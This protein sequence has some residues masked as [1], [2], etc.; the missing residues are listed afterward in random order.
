MCQAHQGAFACG[1]P[2]QIEPDASFEGA[3]SYPATVAEC[4]DPM[5][6]DPAK[7][8][9]IK[10]NTQ[11]VIDNKDATTGHPWN[12]FIRFD[13]DDALAGHTVTHVA[14]RVTATDDSLAPSPDSGTP[15]SVAAFT[16]QSLTGTLPAKVGGPLVASKGP[17]TQLEAIDFELPPAIAAASSPVYIGLFPTNNDGVNYWNRDG[18]TPP[19]LLVDIE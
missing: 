17:V 6:P 11:L 1:L 5:Q 7:C 10:G 8:R 19:V 13:L 14:L 18:A 15:Y 12:A 3:L 9:M 16:L 2:S 4:V